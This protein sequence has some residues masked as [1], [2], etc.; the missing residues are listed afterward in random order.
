MLTDPLLL[1]P[2]SSGTNLE[3]FYSTD[4]APGASTRVAAG[5]G[6]FDGMVRSTFRVN[7]SKTKENAP[8]DTIRTL[9]RMDCEYVGD[10]GS[11]GPTLDKSHT[12]SVYLVV[13]Q[14]QDG[15]APTSSMSR[16]VKGFVA[17]LFASGTEATFDSLKAALSST[18]LDRLIN[19]EA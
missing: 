14:P 1:S 15:I 9:I 5:V 18:Y 11:G 12:A 3:S 7:H 2:D 17:S 8:A 19:G 10:D 4:F 6:H 16:L 13:V